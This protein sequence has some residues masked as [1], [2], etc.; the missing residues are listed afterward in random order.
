MGE[1]NTMDIYLKRSLRKSIKRG[2]PW[3]YKEALEI[4]KSLKK[5]S[6]FVLLKDNKGFVA[7]GIYDSKGA[8]AFRSLDFNP[9][10]LSELKPHLLSVIT[11]RNR[12]NT[13]LTSGFRL[14][15]GEGDGFSGLVCDV[16]KHV[17]VVQF[18]GPG[19]KDFW[20]KTKVFE[21]IAAHFENIKTVVYKPRCDEDLVHLH[22]EALDS[23]IISFKENGLQFE[24]DILN[25]QKTGFFFD[26]RDNREYLKN[27]L[28]ENITEPLKSIK[29]RTVLNAFSYTGGFSVY[30]GASESVSEVVSLDFSKGAV[31]D[32]QKN[33]ELNAFDLRIHKTLQIDAFEYFKNKKDAKRFDVVLVDPPS[34]SSSLE[35]KQKAIH[36][37][38]ELFSDAAAHVVKG[39]DLF[40]SSCSSQISFE[41]FN[42][43]VIEALSLANKKA[44]VHRFSGQGFD[45]PYPHFCPELRYLKFIHLSLD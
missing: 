41:D 45:H 28:K 31:A 13:S 42:K 26:Q 19:M 30:A 44:K 20:L 33:W 14:I 2:H 24:S 8:I 23:K 10:K 7:M 40:L 6:D 36:K 34:M 29:K 43:I 12:L 35:T 4:P 5:L 9:L 21:L 11:K 18:D 15:N 16:Y 25:G 22:G 38:I 1:K 39:G 27:F 17:C 32:A 3:V 37:Y